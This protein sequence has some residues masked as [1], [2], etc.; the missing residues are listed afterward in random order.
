MELG[1]ISSNE[2]PR[3][4]FEYGDTKVLIQHTTKEE[5]RVMSRKCT[6]TSFD[7]VSHA[8]VET[9]D[10]AKADVML[11]Q[12]C[13]KGWEGFTSNGEPFPCT[14]QNIELL[15]TKVNSF[16]KFINDTCTNYETIVAKQKEED[17]KNS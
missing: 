15:M 17:A 6:S 16:S 1:S 12:H 8:P 10:S 4:W 2:S 7:K 5:L 9:M 11:A 14:P 13:I 3:A